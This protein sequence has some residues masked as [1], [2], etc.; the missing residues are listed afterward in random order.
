MQRSFAPP[1]TITL[2]GSS[3][4]ASPST[5]ALNN[6][7]MFIGE[8]LRLLHTRFVSLINT[9]WGKVSADTVAGAVNRIGVES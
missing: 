6:K 1:K 5:F 9:L 3:I 4:P 2:E 8:R 7:K